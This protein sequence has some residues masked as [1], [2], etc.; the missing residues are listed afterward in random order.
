[1]PTK[2]T[3]FFEDFLIENN[4]TIDISI[5][6]YGQG[7]ATLGH[8]LFRY[9]YDHIEVGIAETFDDWDNSV[10]FVLYTM[11]F[12]TL[13]FTAFITALTR[14]IAEGSSVLGWGNATDIGPAMRK[15]K[16]ELKA[17]SRIAGN[18]EPT[19]QITVCS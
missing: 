7:C 16:A 17:A 6:G 3:L 13:G 1:M 18:P 8:L 5:D 2:P 4:A 9:T 19:E 11:P 14:E 12:D 15:V 10:E